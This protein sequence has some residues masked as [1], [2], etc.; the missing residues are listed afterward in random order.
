MVAPRKRRHAKSMTQKK[1]REREKEVAMSEKKSN[2]TG[3][4]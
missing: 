1:K 4:K 3:M 2:Y